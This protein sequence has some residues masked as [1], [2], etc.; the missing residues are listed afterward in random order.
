MCGATARVHRN[1]PFRLTLITESKSSSDIVLATAPSFI[2]TS[3]ASR[4][5]PALLISTSMRPQRA[6]TSWTPCSIESADATFTSRNR[7]SPPAAFSCSTRL[8]AAA[9]FTSQPATRAPSSAKRIAV[10]RPMPAAAPVTI[11]TFLCSPDGFMEIS[12]LAVPISSGRLSSHPKLKLE[13]ETFLRSST[14]PQ[15]G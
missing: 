13:T 12:S 4:T 1:T 8:A 7:A 6:S 9:A 5:I 3:C 11:T 10:A 15:T 2:F 14:S